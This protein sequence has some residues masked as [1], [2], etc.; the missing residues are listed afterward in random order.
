MMRGMN[1]NGCCGG[2]GIGMMLVMGVGF[3]LLLLVV[4]WLFKQLRK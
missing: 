4:F 1:M 2:M 3:V